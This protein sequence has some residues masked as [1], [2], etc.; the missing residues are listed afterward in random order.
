MITEVMKPKE[1]DFE[2]RKN[3]YLYRQLR[4][5]DK[6][7]IY[8]Q[9]DEESARTVGHEVF[10]RKVQRAQDVVLGGKEI[11]YESKERFPGNNDFGSWAWAFRT[12]ERAEEKFNELEHGV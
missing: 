1:L 6:A 5:G 7:F 2:I 9:I 11:S 10:K 12:L 3:G 4:R 8:E